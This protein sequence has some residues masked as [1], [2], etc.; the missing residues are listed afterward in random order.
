MSSPPSA[1]TPPRQPR[2]AKARPTQLVAIIEKSRS[3][4]LRVM[5]TSWRGDHR[6]EIREAT[7]L[8]SGSYFA[9]A[10]GITIGIENLGELIAALQAAEAEARQRKWLSKAA[11]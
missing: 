7:V 8:I 5:L 1:T 4:Q 3:T 9:T 6:I 2:A 10:S 11:P